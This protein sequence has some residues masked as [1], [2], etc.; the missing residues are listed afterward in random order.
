MSVTNTKFALKPVVAA[1][2]LTMGAG[3]AYAAPTPNQMP[4]A[5]IIT[6]VSLGSTN[7]VGTPFVN[8]ASPGGIG[9]DGK[10]VIQ[11]GGPGTAGLGETTNPHGFNLGSNAQ[12][13]FSATTAGSAVLNVDRSGNASQIYGLLA[14]VPGLGFSPALFVANAN[15]IVVGAGGRIVAPTGVGLIGAD[16]SSATSQND[17]VANNGWDL[18]TPPGTPVLGTS[19]LSYG[20]IPATGNVSIAG[21]INGDIAVNLPAQYIFIGGNNVNVLNTGNLFGTYTQIEAGLVAVAGV[22]S[23]GGLTNQTVNRIFNVDTG[24]FQALPVVAPFTGA[25]EVVPG[26]TGNVINEGSISAAGKA[27]TEVLLIQASGN[28]RSGILGSTDNQVGLFSDQGVVIDSFSDTGKVELYNVVSGYTTNKTL[29]VL[30]VNYFATDYLGLGATTF[31]PDVTINAITPG[32]QPSSIATTYQVMIFGGNVSIESTINHKT[33]SDGGV[34]SD[35]VLII[36]GSKSVNISADIGAGNSVYVTSDGP[37]TISGNVLSDSNEGGAGGIYIYNTASGAPTTISGNL[38]VPSS[39]GSYNYLDVITNGPTTISGNLT[40]VNGSVDVYNYGTTA[41]NFTTI[42]GNIVA[43]GYV[44]I[45]QAVSPANAPMTISGD[46]TADDDVYIVNL[47]SSG[48]NTTTISGNVTSNDSFVYIEHR[49]LPTGLLTVTGTVT[50]DDYVYLFSDGHAQISAVNAGNYISATVMGTTFGIN[51]AWTAGD[52]IQ[53]YSPI[54]MTKLKPAGVLTADYVSLYGLNYT[55]VN[56][57]GMTYA[58]AGEKPA[59]QIVTND[60]EVYLTG[61]INGPIAGNTNWPL[62]SMDVA[63][64]Y[65]LSP[66]YVSVTADGGGFQAVNLHVL[67]DAIVDSGGTTTPFIGVPLTT[68]GLPAGGIQGNLGSQLILQADGYMQVWGT[69]TGSVF[70]PD[71]AFQWPGGA[72]FIAGTTL[73]TFDPIYNAWSVA[74]PPFGGVFFEAPYIAMGSFI[75]TSGTAWANFS[76]APV[77]GNPTVYQIR[78][79]TPTAFGFEA[80]TEFVHNAYTHTV[81]GGAPCIVTGPTTW[82]ACP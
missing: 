76:T 23:V 30:L 74:S 16:L 68:G 42:S 39:A 24:L 34:Q 27:S 13:Y 10:V 52:Y 7:V 77:T 21:A 60:L 35:E 47:G 20:T 49:G 17:F 4:G 56:A 78:Q 45:Y 33:E 58:N 18:L 6:A 40:N 5:G 29:P 8:L 53:I 41:G 43:G 28:I 22:D 15:G 51:D 2:A 1:L 75:A 72:T 48:G 67:G 73:Q 46:I 69:P 19:Y 38:T 59:A 57:S 80:T 25:L 70:G 66:V 44:Y 55:G 9:V 26:I 36:A 11:W 37:L 79:L 31:A 81:T 71:Y 64:L 3:A 65:T 63:P 14:S 54:A 62:N 32:A 12:L 61:S 82:T 50:A